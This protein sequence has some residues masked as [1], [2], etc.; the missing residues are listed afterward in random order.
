MSPSPARFA[1][2]IRVFAHEGLARR[3]GRRSSGL[4][5]KRP[6]GRIMPT[7]LTRIARWGLRREK[8]GSRGGSPA[9]AAW[10]VYNGA[11][12]A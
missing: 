2:L 10:Q 5:R 11:Q 3:T 9:R 7:Y 1:L 8:F 4:R 12:N 6:A